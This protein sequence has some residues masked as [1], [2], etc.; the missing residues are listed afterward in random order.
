MIF[1]R[2]PPAY[3]HGFYQ[4]LLFLLD[5]HAN[6]NIVKRLQLARERE[7]QELTKRGESHPSS[8]SVRMTLRSDEAAGHRS[9]AGTRAFD[10]QR[11]V[12]SQ[13]AHPPRSAER[14]KQ[15][16]TRRGRVAARARVSMG[17]DAGDSKP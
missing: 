15:G 6:E 12:K 1:M 9:G 7:R 5:A 17:A 14:N 8:E 11:S 2:C 10:T 16:R 13:E 3:L 4:P